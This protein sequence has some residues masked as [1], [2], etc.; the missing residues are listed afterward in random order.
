MSRLSRAESD[1]LES[2]LCRLAA[3]LAPITVRGLYYQAVISPTLPFITKDK[4]GSRTHYR[5]VQ[6]RILDLRRSGVIPWHAVV[7][8]SRPDYSHDRWTSPS[9][10]AEVAPLYY[11]FD[12]WADQPVRP[13]VMVEKAG[14]IPVYRQH[15]DCFGVDVVACKGY[16]SASQLWELATS[17]SGWVDSDQQIRVLVCAD[18]DPSGND[19]PRA[20]EVEIRNH[21]NVG[22]NRLMFDRVL[23]NPLDLRALGSAVAFRQPNPEDARTR[24]FLDQYGFNPADEVCVEM[25]AINPNEARA[26]LGRIYRD[27]YDGDIDAALA[28]E[29]NHR[30][31]ITQA[32]EALC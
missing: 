11:R 9:G 30:E 24:S 6:G 4:E 25:D 17:I 22:P 18:F 16:G 13:L 10:F 29:L 15:A 7:D 23:V 12:A 3:E 32:L 20:A 27:L 2:E 14:Q 31:V 8:E 21:L 19:W 26:R 28:Q 5:H 1:L